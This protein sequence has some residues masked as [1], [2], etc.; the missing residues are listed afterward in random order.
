[1]VEPKAATIDVETGKP[2][3]CT[4][5]NLWHFCGTLLVSEVVEEWFN[6][7]ETSTL[8][9]KSGHPICKLTL[10]GSIPH[11]SFGGFELRNF[12]FPR[13][14]SF[15]IFEELPGGGVP[16]RS[17]KT[18][19]LG[20]ISQLLIYMYIGIYYGVILYPTKN[21]DQMGRITMI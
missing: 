16:V 15:S 19:V 13:F 3:N 10:P 2:G 4:S 21:G 14:F 8:T 20:V 1:V 12:T 7:H 6:R 17:G 18:M 5:P 9:P 11:I